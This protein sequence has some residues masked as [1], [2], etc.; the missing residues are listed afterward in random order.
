MQCVQG[1]LV[2]FF[3]GQLYTVFSA[4]NYCGQVCLPTCLPLV[5]ILGAE[6]FL[7]A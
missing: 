7:R 5:G 6:T 1:G 4:S 3:G 2:R